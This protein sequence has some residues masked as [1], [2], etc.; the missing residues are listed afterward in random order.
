MSVLEGG[1]TNQDHVSDPQGHCLALFIIIMFMAS[2][3]LLLKEVGLSM[4]PFHVFPQFLDVLGELGT[5]VNFRVN[6]R[7][8]SMGSQGCL[9]YMRK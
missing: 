2:C 1:D 9:L 5:V 6:P 3:L 4:G 8:T 7:I